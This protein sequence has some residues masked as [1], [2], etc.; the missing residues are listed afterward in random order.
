MLKLANAPESINKDFNIPILAEICSRSYKQPNAYQE[1]QISTGLS[2]NFEQIS[3]NRSVNF[4][5]QLYLLFKRNWL[6]NVRNPTSLVAMIF[7]ALSN[8][9]LLSAVFHD[10]GKGRFKFPLDTYDNVVHN[11]QVQENYLGLVFFACL[12]SFMIVSLF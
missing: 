6:F 12:D 2:Q 7:I 4:F 8:G 11:N 1:K 9:F 10:L 5:K 3:G